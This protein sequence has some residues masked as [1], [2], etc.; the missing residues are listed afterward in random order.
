MYGAL[1]A[2]WVYMEAFNAV[3]SSLCQS[4]IY[5][6]L[7]ASL[8]PFLFL[9]EVKMDICNMLKVSAELIISIVL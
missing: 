9:D 2:S 7:H 5:A 3:F 4:I 1:N 8:M 6:V